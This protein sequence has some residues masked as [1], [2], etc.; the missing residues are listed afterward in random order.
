VMELLGP[1]LEDLF[2]FC[3]RKFS[4]KTVLLLADQMIS[5]I[6]YIHGKNFLH[7]DIKPDNF[8]MGLGKKGNLVYAIDFGLAKRFR[9]PRTHQHIPYR[10][11]KN[12]TGTAR[13]AS[14]N[15]HLG[16][17]QSRRDDLEAIGYIFI[18]FYKGILPWQGLKA[19]TKAQKYDKISDKKLSTPVEELC[20]GTPA[21]FSTYINYCRSL[22]FEEKPDYA[23]LRQLIRNLFHRQ[24]FSYDYVFDWNAIKENQSKDS[25]CSTTCDPVVGA[26]PKE[27]VPSPAVAEETRERRHTGGNQS[28]AQEKPPHG[29]PPSSPP[30]PVPG[31]QTHNKAHNVSKGPKSRGQSAMPID[32]VQNTKPIPVPIIIPPS[33][34]PGEEPYENENCQQGPTIV[35]TACTPCHSTPPHTPPGFKGDLPSFN[36]ITATPTP[37]VGRLTPE[38]GGNGASAI[39]LNNNTICDNSKVM[40]MQSA[41]SDMEMEKS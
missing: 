4:L 11:H 2:N 18:Y 26:T 41:R 31:S 37:S 24:G 25:G 5:R 8:L 1:S 34:D 33:P 12:L 39:V 23:Y 16:I 40:N 19:R 27:T 21:E 36:F 14:I 32:I 13:Y 20:K 22:R 9:D 28:G 10:E 29:P 6:E 30:P 15:T 3:H 38:R 35:L 7:R 17:E